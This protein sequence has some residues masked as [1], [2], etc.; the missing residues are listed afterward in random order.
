MK[1]D[2]FRRVSCDSPETLLETV[3]FPKKIPNQE[4][5]LNYGILG[6]VY[7]KIAGPGSSLTFCYGRLMSKEMICLFSQ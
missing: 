2:S 6:S 5:T 3:R 4:I 1:T 7:E